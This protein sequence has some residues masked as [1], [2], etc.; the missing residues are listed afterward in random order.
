MRIHTCFWIL[1]SIGG[2]LLCACTA[3]ES[4]PTSAAAVITFAADRQ[5]LQA[6]ECTILR[7]SAEA[8]FGVLFDGN[9]VP[10]TGQKEVC[11]LETQKYILE[12]DLGTD[13]ERREVEIR[14]SPAATPLPEMTR[15]LQ[16]PT[17]T[18]IQA[19]L[20]IT[21][22]VPAYQAQ[23]WENLGGPPGDL[24]YDIR[25][26]FDDPN[27]WYVTDGSGGFFIST[28]RGLTWGASNEGISSL[29]GSLERPVFSATVDPHN[30]QTI[31]IGTRIV[32][33][34]YKSTDGGRHWVEMDKGIIP[35]AGHHF[36]GFT[37]DPRSSDIVYAMA[38]VDCELM[39]DACV[40]NTFGGR[41]YRTQNGGQ[42][43]ELFWEGEALA[44]Y[45][46][47]D[48][49]DYDTMYIST[50]IFDRYPL[51]MDENLK[52][53][54]T[55]G[56]G[57]IKTTDGG[58]TWSVI[59]KSNG[60]S[61]LYVSSLYLNPKNPQVLLAGTGSNIG[62]I[63]YR[64]PET[65][66]EASYGGAFLSEDGGQTWK[67][68]IKNDVIGAVE[69]CEQDPSIAYAGGT[70]GF[71]RSQDGGHTWT[72]HTDAARGTWG[73]AGV[74]PGTPID[75]QT[76]PAD[77]NRLFINNYV[78]G[79]FLSEDGGDTW[80]LATVGY[81]GAEVM[82]LAIDTQDSAHVYAA[83]RMAPFVSRDGGRSWQGLTDAAL[84]TGLRV[85]VI[86][87]A[88]PDHLLGTKQAYVGEIFAS[89]DGGQN[90][91]SVYKF[92]YPEGTKEG[93]FAY[94][95]GFWD[96]AFA[97]SDPQIVYAA[98]RNWTTSDSI[99]P[100]YP[101][102]GV[103]RSEDGGDTWQPA[104]DSHTEGLAIGAVQVHPTDPQVVYAASFFT[105]GVFKTT[106][107]GK[108]WTPINSGLP[109]PLP[110]IEVIAIN[111]QSPETIYIAGQSGVFKSTDGGGS[112]KQLAAGLDPT[113][114]IRA[115][116][117]D[118]NNG[119]TIYL[120]MRHL[121]IYYSTDGGETFQP[122]TQGLDPLEGV[123][124]ILSLAL[125]SD[126]SVL[127]AGTMGLSTW[128]LDASSGRNP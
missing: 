64:D 92:R 69:F 114:G 21:P 1:L 8:G 108:N 120:G 110:R 52:N 58:K 76:D 111:A 86:D 84:G 27:T 40:P 60:L 61:I 19:T 105:S 29:E 20:V 26:N 95:M 7:W 14:V 13:L 100:V 118:P 57:I 32:G 70:M 15:T 48:P 116:V 36:R 43:W 79:N 5:V 59:G 24:G 41:V 112:W 71:Y 87:P 73:P 101:G 88:D 94:Q 67:Q 54:E 123:M 10:K 37:I 74:W 98:T 3:Q 119:D 113:P 4:T 99:E 6:G 53:W 104:N 91:T 33:H 31:W 68:V 103:Y 107:G 97:P 109:Q 23:G 50:G 66:K 44:R 122:L 80:Q 82:D 128:K 78:G 90:W 22:G 2:M 56:L 38:E 51:N 117:L 16:P 46:W 12:V 47:I 83:V 102:L 49:T 121:G 25:Y 28:D 77:C 115:M 55:S 30:P 17:P 81:S 35:H 62:M 124:P 89:H 63:I 18:S 11:P 126:G 39:R 85:L 93:D 127:Y 42:S 106:D 9:S 34:I 72:A 125:S 65:G 45:L 75:I 96:F